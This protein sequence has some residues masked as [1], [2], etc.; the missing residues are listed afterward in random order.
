MAGPNDPKT[1]FDLVSPGIGKASGGLV[2][3]LLGLVTL[4]IGF[5]MDL[6]FIKQAGLTMTVMGFMLLAYGV[7]RVFMGMEAKTR[8]V[9]CPHCG[10][11]NQILANVTSFPCFK[12]EKP[13]KI[14]AKKAG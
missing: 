10:E 5:A 7:V 3:F 14:P 13:L 12:C 8:S 11:T 6:A 1:R 4:G 9:K 2:T